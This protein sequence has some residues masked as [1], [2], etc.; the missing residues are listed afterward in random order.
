M[1]FKMWLK[2]KFAS[3]QS[4]CNKKG[5]RIYGFKALIFFDFFFENILLLSSQEIPFK[6]H[7]QIICLTD[8]IG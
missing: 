1:V 6:H 3:W 7:P 2:S 4:R 5:K 8:L